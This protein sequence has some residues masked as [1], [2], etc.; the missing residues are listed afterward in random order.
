M[1]KML[2]TEPVIPI[3]RK[4]RDVRFVGGTEG[5]TEMLW[6]RAHDGADWSD[7]RA[8]PLTTQAN[9][10]PQLSISDASLSVG[11]NVAASTLFTYSDAEGEAA[12]RYEF[13]DSGPDASSGYFAIDGVQQGEGMAIPLDAA[14]LGLVMAVGGAEGGTEPL[15][16]RASDGGDWSEWY[17]ITLTTQ[18][19]SAPQL[20]LF[21]AS[22]AVS[23]GV[24]ASTLFT[25]SDAEGDPAVRYEFWDSG[26]AASSGYFAID[27]VQQ[28]EGM[29]IP[30]DAADLGLVTV[31]GGSEGG[32][33]TL[34][35]RANDGAGWGG[36]HMVALTTVPNAAPQLTLSDVSLSIDASVAASTLFT[37]SD[38]EGESAVR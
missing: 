28:G 2:I 15:W 38:A 22:L 25:Y 33:E 36:W 3:E 6:V 27:G 17:M 31:V 8:I 32:T 35:V 10:A 20:T 18:P 23:A 14:D 26:P 24:A 9:A 19:N 5:G 11:E 37:N 34:W 16:V 4:G 7:W 29:A 12:V 1:L 13:W 21:D 30:V